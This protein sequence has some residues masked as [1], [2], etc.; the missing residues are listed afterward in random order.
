MT[1]Q[2]IISISQNCFPRS[3]TNIAPP[4]LPVCISRS[5]ARER[6][7]LCQSRA[8]RGPAT[9]TVTSC[10]GPG[11]SQ[12]WSN[13][14]ALQRSHEANEAL[15]GQNSSGST[16]GLQVFSSFQCEDVNKH[17]GCLAL[18]ENCGQ[19]TVELLKRRDK[20]SRQPPLMFISP[21]GCSKIDRKHFSLLLN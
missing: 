21:G 16:V 20:D 14:A 19:K 17:L 2:R 7:Q 5:A 6:L 9:S 10:G 13:T 3:Q 1:K 15:S 11:A 18:N 12:P 4:L 8:S